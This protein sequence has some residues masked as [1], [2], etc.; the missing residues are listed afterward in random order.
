MGIVNS[1]KSFM[2]FDDEE[3]ESGMDEIQQE[4][5][6]RNPKVDHSTQRKHNGK[7]VSIQQQI[8]SEVVI[9]QPYNFDDGHQICDHLK[10]RKPIVVNIEEMDTSEAQRIIDF[11][12]GSVC[13]LDGKIKKVSNT[14]FLI[15]PRDME[16]SGNVKD[17][18]RSSKVNAYSV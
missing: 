5:E 1:M 9:M 15:V 17:E 18:Y 11:L 14:I 12:C 7:I 6:F 4:V 8:S 3:E 10:N 13:A 16:I 2:G